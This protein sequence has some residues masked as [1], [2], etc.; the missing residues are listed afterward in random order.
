MIFISN[1]L[2]LNFSLANSTSKRSGNLLTVLTVTQSPS[3]WIHIETHYRAWTLYCCRR[4]MN[5]ESSAELCRVSQKSWPVD[6]WRQVV[7]FI[8]QVFRIVLTIRVQCK[9][10][11][12]MINNSPSVREF[13][14]NPEFIHRILK[15][16]TIVIILLRS[17]SLNVFELFNSEKCD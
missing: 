13:S 15:A 17:S 12:I 10:A 8:A 14:L 6:K 2:G 4:N 7:K 16:M 5:V 3:H 11:T 1:Y 9:A